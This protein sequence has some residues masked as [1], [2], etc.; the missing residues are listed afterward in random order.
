MRNASYWYGE[1][2][3][4]HG[5]TCFLSEW[6]LLSKERII[7]HWEQILEKLLFVKVVPLDKTVKIY[8]ENPYASTLVLVSSDMLA[9][10][11]SVDPDQLA[12]PEANWSGSALFAIKYS[13][14]L[15]RINNLDQV[16]WFIAENWKWAWHLNLFRMTRVKNSHRE[17][18]IVLQDLA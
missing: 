4:G 3:K 13:S 2:I 11:N 9:F 15:I 16:I 10:T 6:G 17:I 14:M 5:N 12:S 7:Y 1:C 18:C 8:Q